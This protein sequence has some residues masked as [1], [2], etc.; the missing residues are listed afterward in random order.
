MNFLTR[1]K[2]A[3]VTFW[4]KQLRVMIMM[5]VMLMVTLKRQESGRYRS[6]KQQCQV[7]VRRHTS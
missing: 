7:S 4:Q 1:K 2:T 6:A 3:S 5:M